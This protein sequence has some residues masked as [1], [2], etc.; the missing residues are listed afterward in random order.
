MRIL[1]KTCKWETVEKHVTTRSLYKTIDFYNGVSLTKENIPYEKRI[2]K[3]YQECMLIGT[4][5][6]L[7][8]CR[9]ICI[10]IN[11]VVL[12]TIDVAKLLGVNIDC[13]L[14]WSY[15]K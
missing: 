11:N 8:K 13:T 1:I 7:V 14:S 12:E 4:K 10:E 3:C 9:K 2:V 6:R 15:Q 5:Q